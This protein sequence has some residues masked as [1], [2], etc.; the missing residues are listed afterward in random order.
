MEQFYTMPAPIQWQAA[1]L[2]SSHTLER[3]GFSQATNTPFWVLRKNCP[4]L[5]L[6]GSGVA[7]LNYAWVTPTWASFSTLA[8]SSILKKQ[9]HGTKRSEATLMRKWRPILPLSSLEVGTISYGQQEHVLIMDSVPSETPS[10]Q[11]KDTHIPSLFMK[12]CGHSP[13]LKINQLI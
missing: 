12:V 7:A 2:Q 4:F 5:F 6:K 10:P 3:Q 1:E 8:N 11:Y 9:N 13:F